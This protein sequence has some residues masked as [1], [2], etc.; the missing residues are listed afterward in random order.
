[1]HGPSRDS[2]D[3]HEAQLSGDAPKAVGPYML[4]DLR[5]EK[6]RMA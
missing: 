1:M 4:A 6:S 2:L 3:F 5:A